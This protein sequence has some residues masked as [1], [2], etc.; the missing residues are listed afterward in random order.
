MSEHFSESLLRGAKSGNLEQV[1]QSWI[2]AEDKYERDFLGHNALTLAIIHD[3]FDI[4]K[5]LVD[6][7]FVL[8]LVNDVYSNFIMLCGTTKTRY[9]SEHRGDDSFLGA[10]ALICAVKKRNFDMV[11]YLVEKGASVNLVDKEGYGALYYAIRKRCDKE[12]IEYLI[13]EGSEVEVTCEQV[14]EYAEFHQDFTSYWSELRREL[15][16]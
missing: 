7:G 2:Q 4:F 9:L 16:I 10:T 8:D 14:D 11:R 5:Y 13:R 3:H 1:K 12:M 6:T 15:E